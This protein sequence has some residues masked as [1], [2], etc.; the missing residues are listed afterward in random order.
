MLYELF[1]Y[2]LEGG[3]VICLKGVV[4]GGEID[5]SNLYISLLTNI[6]L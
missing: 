6:I 3:T 4:F 2:C 5:M 1:G